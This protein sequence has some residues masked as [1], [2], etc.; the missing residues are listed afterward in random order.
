MKLNF[1]AGDTFDQSDSISGFPSTSGWTLYHR[2][3]PTAAAGTGILLTSTGQADGSHRTYVAPGT[4][5]AWATGG[6]SYSRYISNGTNRSTLGTGVLTVL[7]DPATATSGVDNRSHARKVLDALNATIEG[8]A[9]HDMA[10]YMI[11][12]RQV[13]L[14]GPDALIKWRGYYQALVNG[15]E[16]KSGQRAAPGLRVRFR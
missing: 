2:L 3:S 1:T 7:A 4:T 16:I 11:Q 6:Y 14:L 10:Q 15:E 9:T 13:T 8:R 5:A 12:G